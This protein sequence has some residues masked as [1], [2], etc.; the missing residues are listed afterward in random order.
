M[1]ALHYHSALDL[2]K[3]LRERGGRKERRKAEKEKEM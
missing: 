1:K 3:I 2:Y